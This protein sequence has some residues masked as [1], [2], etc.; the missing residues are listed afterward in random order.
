MASMSGNGELN[1]RQRLAQD[2]AD[3][4]D[5]IRSTLLEAA[6]V[7]KPV[8]VACPECM[9]RSQVEVPDGH[10]ALKATELLINQGYGRPKEAATD[11][12]D[13]VFVRKIV[14]A[15]TSPS[16]KALRRLL[17]AVR[18]IDRPEVREA[19]ANV[20]AELADAIV[21]T[22]TDRPKSP[23]NAA[24]N[25]PHGLAAIARESSKSLSGPHRP[26]ASGRWPLTRGGP[27]SPGKTGSVFDR[28]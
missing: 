25:G 12:G 28:P 23:T 18:D 4:Y 21:S 14:R 15:G 8:W 20:E 9:K 22:S 26:P 19:A 17:D 6:K 3:E 24:I 16:H 27:I 10:V 13:F 2:A 1:V 7:M 11:N 5:L